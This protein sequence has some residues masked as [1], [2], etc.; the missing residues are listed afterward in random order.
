MR[1]RSTATDP[2][3]PLRDPFAFYS[4]GILRPVE[5]LTLPEHLDGADGVLD[6]LFHASGGGMPSET[7]DARNVAMTIVHKPGGTPV[8]FT[9]FDLWSH[10]RPD[11]V[12]L[13][14]FVLQNEWGL[15][16]GP[17]VSIAP[18][19]RAANERSRAD[20]PAVGLRA[21]RGVRQ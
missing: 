7:G 6:T 13:I 1:R 11:C 12:A 21:R 18:S 16:R 19:V 20:R 14:D 2:L 4:P 15:S 5:C 3:P 10:A 9:A 17:L 8:V